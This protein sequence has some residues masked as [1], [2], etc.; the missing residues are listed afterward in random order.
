MQTL[1]CPPSGEQ[2][3]KFP[4]SGGFHAVAMSQ[5]WISS[6]R[7]FAHW[8]CARVQNHKNVNGLERVLRAVLWRVQGENKVL[9][10]STSAVQENR[11]SNRWANVHLSLAFVS[12]HDTIDVSISS[13]RPQISFSIEYGSYLS[14]VYCYALLWNLPSWNYKRKKIETFSDCR[15]VIVI[16]LVHLQAQHNIWVKITLRWC[17]GSA[18]HYV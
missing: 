18:A 1:L 11:S 4:C 12:V 17:L 7:P 16:M 2:S 13:L 6:H 8:R 3:Q 15:P 9:H 10:W 5:C 14:H